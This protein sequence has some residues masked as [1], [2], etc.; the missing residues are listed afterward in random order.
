M[1]LWVAGEPREGASTPAST[2][3]L[4][5]AR[6]RVGKPLQVPGRQGR[7]GREHGAGATAPATHRVTLAAG[8]HIR[9]RGAVAIGPVPHVAAAGHHCGRSDGQAAGVA[10]DVDATQCWS[11]TQPTRH[12]RE[13]GKD[14][15]RSRSAGRCMARRGT[16]WRDARQGVASHG[17]PV[18]RRWLPPMPRASMSHPP[19]PSAARQARV[20]AVP[21]RRSVFPGA[22]GL[23]ENMEG[24]AVYGIVG[25]A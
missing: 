1:A 21:M 7:T 22:V 23:R 19:V 15:S 6:L 25:A 2:S 8:L 24:E 10:S 9:E 12:R 17:A 20:P 18:Q 16:L 5:S 3:Y 13:G 4:A 14:E 11:W